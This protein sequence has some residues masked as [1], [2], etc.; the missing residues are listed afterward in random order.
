MPL[1]AMQFMPAQMIAVL[2]YLEFQSKICQ[3]V[4]LACRYTQQSS[5]RSKSRLAASPWPTRQAGIKPFCII[6]QTQ[7]VAHYFSA[8]T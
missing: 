4:G 2:C 1:A 5:I 6:A 8:S 3:E 7:L